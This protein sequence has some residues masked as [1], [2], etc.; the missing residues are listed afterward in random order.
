MP[1]GRAERPPRI[2]TDVSTSG[3]G[4]RI[5][6]WNSMSSNAWRA[7]EERQLAL[8]RAVGVIESGLR[9][10]PLGD[11]AQVV[12]R[13]RG[14]EAALL[15]VQL[16]LLELHELEKLGGIGELALHHRRS[17]RQARARPASA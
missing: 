1:K 4:R 17:F 12:D 7:R 6:G 11:R 5:P 15:A 8:R 16:G 14:V 3:A 10:S 9:R 13:E 2:S